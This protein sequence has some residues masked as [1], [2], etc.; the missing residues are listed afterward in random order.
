MPARELDDWAAYWRI[1]PWGA[2]RDNLHAGLIASVIANAHRKP[3]TRA[4]T[5]QDF[6]VTD[7]ESHRKR[8]TEQSLAWMRSVAKPKRKANP[9]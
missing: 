8:Q 6:M 9:Q 4:L 2:W 1:E 5:Y 7:R 3:S